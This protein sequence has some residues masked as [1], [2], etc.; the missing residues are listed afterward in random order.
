MA[1]D[2]AM[3]SGASFGEV[4]PQPVLHAPPGLPPPLPPPPPPPAP[5]RSLPTGPASIVDP[6]NFAT[7]APPR[8]AV[9]L[10]ASQPAAA[11]APPTMAAP[12][13]AVVRMPSA[14]PPEP[15]VEEEVHDPWASLAAK[16]PREETD[17]FAGLDAP[18]GGGGDLSLAAPPRPSANERTG[19]PAPSPGPDSFSSSVREIELR[20]P[21]LG[22]KLDLDYGELSGVGGLA[23]ERATENAPPEPEE[24]SAE[25]A[26]I[27]TVPREAVE[28]RF[29]AGTRIRGNNRSGR[30]LAS[31]LL[32]VLSAA[33]V[34]YA[35]IVTVAVIRTPRPL[36]WD[37]IGFPVVWLAFGSGSADQSAQLRATN[38]HTGIYPVASGDE[39]FY[40]DGTAEND[41]SRRLEKMYV[42]LEIRRNGR[43]LETAYAIAGLRATPDD[44]Y[45]LGPPSADKTITRNET[46]QRN[47]AKRATSLTIDAHKSVP[48][49]G[50]F[51]AKAKD[52]E[53]SEIRATVMDGYPT[54]MHGELQLGVPSRSDGA[55]PVVH[56]SEKPG[57]AAP[58][59]ETAG[60]SVAAAKLP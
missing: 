11:V 13:S 22:G 49:V 2:A 17:P 52:V 10:H 20:E 29:T 15:A 57:A 25:V 30:E 28:E 32:N 50:I 44:L 35:A 40:V 46:L 45:A 21:T 3:A 51:E 47:L 42:Q 7:R 9:K 14:P 5:L 58:A 56:P 18:N 16:P 1:L 38:L 41:S 43:L 54:A 27:S 48:F 23:A 24:Q 33:I 36:R 59:A 60:K 31:A 39:V 55:A 37:D 8:D 12:V 53:G 19:T 4:V 6:F 34:C 26:R